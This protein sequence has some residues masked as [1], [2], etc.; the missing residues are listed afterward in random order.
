MLVRLHFAC[1]HLLR[2]SEGLDH[3]GKGLL[4]L[5]SLKYKFE[6]KEDLILLLKLSEGGLK[7]AG[8][9]AQGP[10]PAHEVWAQEKWLIM[11]AAKGADQ[12][13]CR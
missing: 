7:V 10:V 12:V 6:Q 4:H 11:A 1:A 13:M 3:G 5:G 9:P 8:S 2:V